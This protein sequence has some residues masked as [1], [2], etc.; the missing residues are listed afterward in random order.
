M[1]TLCED[2]ETQKKGVVVVANV[3]DLPDGDTKFHRALLWRL[4]VVG[5]FPSTLLSEL[6][7]T[8][9]P[10]TQ[11]RIR[12][13]N[14]TSSLPRVTIAYHDL[15]F[16]EDGGI[17]LAN[18]MK[19]LEKRSKKEAYLRRYPPI[20]GAVDLPSK[21]DVLWGKGKQIVGYPGNRLFHELVEAYGDQYNQL[22]KDGKTKLASLIIADIHEYSGRFLKL[23][24]ES[25]M[26]VEVSAL[27]AR[28]KVTHR[29]R[30][31]RAVGLNGGST[32]FKEPSVAWTT[33]ETGGCKRSRMM[34]S[35][36]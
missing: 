22:S 15:P 23:D 27:E 18:H 5:S 11:V 34:F 29:F 26:W 7:S 12:T 31:N 25:G 2:E 3:L 32:H 24:N 30:R 4:N 28:E 1:S 19:W 13:H 17:L 16:A 35:G 33:K 20:E 14:G 36:S 21:H 6:A 10:T 9:R 8:A